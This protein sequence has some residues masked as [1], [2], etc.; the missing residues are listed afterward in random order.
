MFSYGS[1]RALLYD[2]TLLLSVPS[3]NKPSAYHSLS[4]ITAHCFLSIYFDVSGLGTYKFSFKA[5]SFI[6]KQAQEMQGSTFRQRDQAGSVQSP[7]TVVRQ[8][9][10]KNV[11]M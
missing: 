7:L 9:F 2:D 3:N 8:P 6:C 1:F 5:K 11:R 10:L 4:L